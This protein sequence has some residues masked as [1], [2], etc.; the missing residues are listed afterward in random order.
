[1][2]AANYGVAKNENRR[3]MGRSYLW[4]CDV[5]TEVRSTAPSQLILAQHVWGC[6]RV[7]IMLHPL[8]PWAATQCQLTRPIGTIFDAEIG[9]RETALHGG[10]I[11]KP[12]KMKRSAFW[13]QKANSPLRGCLA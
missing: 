10:T 2:G 13:P 8:G 11:D 3:K 4:H 1:M 7:T 6:Y 12:I 9:R 5:A